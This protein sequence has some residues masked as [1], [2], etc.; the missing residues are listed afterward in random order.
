MTSYIGEGLGKN[1]D[2]IAE[3]V[4][5]KYKRDTLGVSEDSF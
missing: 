3:P 1:G 5:V 4:K 2:G